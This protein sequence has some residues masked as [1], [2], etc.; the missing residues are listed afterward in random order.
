MTEMHYWTIAETADRLQ[1]GDVSVLELTE[2]QLDRITAVN[3][4]INAIT[5]PVE[6]ALEVAKALDEQ[7]RPDDAGPLWGVPVTTKINVD[8]KGYPNSNGIPANADAIATED[9]PLVANLR[10]AGAVIVG[11]NNTPEF[12]LRWFTSNPLHGVTHNPWDKTLTPG[13]SSGAAAAAV[14]AGIGAIGHGNDLGGSLRY[15]AY[16]CGVATIR[17]SLGRVPSMNPTQSSMGIERGPITQLMAVQGPI[18]RS[19]ADVRAGLTAMAQEDLRDP[20]WVHQASQQRDANGSLTVGYAVNPFGGQI[21]PAVETAMATAVTAMK[22]SGATLREVIPPF[23]ETLPALWGT[24]MFTETEALIRQA[25]ESN[26]SSEMWRYYQDFVGHF[27]PTD[28]RG[29]LQALQKRA[30]CQRAWAEMFTQVD[31]LILPTSLQRPFLNGLDFKDP[32]ALDDIVPAQSPSLRSM[33]WGCRPLLCQHIWM[34]PRR[35]GCNWSGRCTAM[36]LC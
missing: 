34:A 36:A 17:P 32:A 15:P 5:T 28:V 30:V 25:I 3:P 6:E 21:D 18:A 1:R 23:A 27:E 26:G 35:L 16:C 2:A 7:G 11:R 29:L 31:V 20:L 10:R 13:G 19:I 24:L 14:A 8:Q 4:E 9:S 33:S 22:D 12:S